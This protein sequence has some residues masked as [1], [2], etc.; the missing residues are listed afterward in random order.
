M[1]ISLLYE[2]SMRC[3]LCKSG[4]ESGDAEW[5]CPKCNTSHHV[6]YVSDLNNNE[7]SVYGC[8]AKMPFDAGIPEPKPR[9][10]KTPNTYIA[11][12]GLN[13]GPTNTSGYVPM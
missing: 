7:C 9:T 5:A 10:F 4:F 11:P 2:D 8:S 6:E 13:L 1:K 12:G 3:P